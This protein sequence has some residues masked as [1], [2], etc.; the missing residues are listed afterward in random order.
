MRINF[1]NLYSNF[2]NVKNAGIFSSLDL[3]QNHSF[4]K[5]NRT[6]FLG[7]I[8]D[9][10]NKTEP[11]SVNISLAKMLA[12]L[13]EDLV[14]MPIE[15]YL[16]DCPKDTITKFM[17]KYSPRVNSAIAYASCGLGNLP[18]YLRY[19]MNDYLNNLEAEGSSP[20]RNYI[21]SYCAKHL[22]EIG[23]TYVDKTLP[24]NIISAKNCRIDKNYTISSLKAEA[25]FEASRTLSKM[26]DES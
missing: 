25:F 8:D 18:D 15:E 21:L 16:K 7:S 4:I 11:N 19:C 24:H 2:N 14:L 9:E 3:T 23:K 10:N 5:S 6:T 20:D 17:P 1:F 26:T 12:Y 22:E 13:S